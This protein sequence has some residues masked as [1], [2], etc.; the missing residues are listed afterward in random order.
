MGF[1]PKGLVVREQNVGG[2]PLRRDTS[3]QATGNQDKH[4]R[5]QGVSRENRRGRDHEP[6]IPEDVQAS[7]MDP[8]VRRDLRSLDKRN[9]ETVARHLAMA[10]RLLDEDPLAALAHARAARSRAGRIAV[11][12]ETAGV[13]AYHAGEWAEALGELRAARRMA[14]GSGLLALIADCERGL[15]RPK[16]AI[17]LARS[18]EARE[19]RGEAATELRIVE[20]GARLDLG[21][22]D[23]A[24]VTLQAEKLDPV[25]QGTSA[26]RLFYAYAEALAAAGRRAEARR[27]FENAAAA[28][29]DDETDAEGRAAQ[30]VDDE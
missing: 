24:V 25:R 11:V 9:A 30:L 22:H 3:P 2:K 15:G 14:G 7:E 21:Q 8:A 5:G 12:R 29:V 4:A 27:W 26:A 23:Q 13:V 17:E 10:A 19:L 1:Y 20:A 6:A 28:D 16:R 18:P